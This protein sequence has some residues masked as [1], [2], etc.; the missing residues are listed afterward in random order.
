MFGS[1]PTRRS[2]LD[3]DALSKEWSEER[4]V[5][6]PTSMATDGRHASCCCPGNFAC[7]SPPARPRLS[8]TSLRRHGGSGVSARS[9]RRALER[10]LPCESNAGRRPVSLLAVSERR[11]DTDPV[12]AGPTP[13]GLGS[14]RPVSP[15]SHDALLTERMPDWSSRPARRVVSPT[16]VGWRPNS[17]SAG[18]APR[19]SGRSERTTCL[20]RIAGGEAPSYGSGIAATRR[21]AR[22]RSGARRACRSG[23][24]PGRSRARSPRR[25]S[26]P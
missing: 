15:P 17:S 6:P 11:S 24:R 21:V 3:G 13:W 18:Y 25:E 12:R 10:R 19:W 5:T 16:P 9:T 22:A 2:H 1:G 4:W 20:R 26:V 14:S 7:G 8:R 23:S